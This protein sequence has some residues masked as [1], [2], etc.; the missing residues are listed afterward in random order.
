LVL[1]SWRKLAT[2][3]ALGGWG[4]KNIFMFSKAL[5]AKCKW[6]LIE[7]KGLW[8]HII[9]D[10]YIP[11]DTIVDWI[12]EPEKCSQNGSIIWK[13]ILQDFPLI[14]RWLIWCIGDGSQVLIGKDP[15]IGSQNNHLLP[16]SLIQWLNRDGFFFLNHIMRRDF[17]TGHTH[18]LSSRDL[19]LDG[20]HIPLW[21][22]YIISLQNSFMAPL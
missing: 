2:P 17:T 4:I 9:K 18:W 22:S 10:K 1:A 8:A 20:E 14:G 19:D 6:R 16:A 11:H 21:D 12:R 5:A 7:G 3:K 13:A 15:W